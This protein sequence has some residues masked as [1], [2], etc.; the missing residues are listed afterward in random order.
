MGRARRRVRGGWA[1]VTTAAA[2]LLVV[3]VSAALPA[4]AGDPLGEV[5]EFTA[6]L[7]PDS[8]PNRIA[9]G[10]DGN[11]WFTEHAGTGSAGSRRPASSP[12]SPPT[13]R[14]DSHP[15]SI[16]AGPDG[17][18]WF[19]EITIGNR[20]GRITP[21]GVVTE[22]T[23]GITADSRP[24]GITAG[25]DGN[26]WF[27]EYGGEPHRPD[28]AGRRRHRVHAPASPPAAGPSEITAGP[29]G[30]LW[31]T[32]GSATASGG[33]RRPARSPSSAAGLTAN[34]QPTGITAGPGRQ[35][36]VHRV[37]RSGRIGRITPAGA[38]TSSRMA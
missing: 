19:T 14:A 2:V 10:P 27:T 20:I 34:S 9:D 35:P 23:A 13:S 18:L 37:H 17:N 38:S 5:K 31:F 30:N 29:D 36:V 11:L 26:L 24:L 12:S 25:P 1:R 15:A 7:T 28:H 22:F 21:A 3:S 8:G 6:G 4:V 32:E 16:A 33:S